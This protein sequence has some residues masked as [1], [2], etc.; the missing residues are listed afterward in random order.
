MVSPGPMPTTHTRVAARAGLVELDA[1]PLA[2]PQ[3]AQPARDG[4]PRRDDDLH[5]VVEQRRPGAV[6]LDAV[7]GR[8][9][10]GNGSARERRDAVRPQ[11]E[12]TAAASDAASSTSTRSPGRS[13]SR[14]A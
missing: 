8:L 11:P 5:A 12:R 14:R 4:R 7:D 13:R 1:H 9:H 3:V 6:V 10:T 2:H